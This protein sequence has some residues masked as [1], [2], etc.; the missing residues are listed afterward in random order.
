MDL[1]QRLALAVD[2]DLRRPHL[3]RG[4]DLPR[5]GGH[6]PLLGRGAA[7]RVSPHHRGGEPHR[8][9]HAARLRDHRH[10]LR[11]RVSRQG[12]GP[13][14]ARLHGAAPT[15]HVVVAGDH[16]L[17]RSAIR[18]LPAVRRARA[19]CCRRIGCR[20]ASWRLA[21]AV[22]F[23]NSALLVGL[24]RPFAGFFADTIFRPMLVIA[25]F[26][27]RDDGRH[28]RGRLHRDGLDA[29][30]RLCRASPL[31]Q[32]LFVLSAIR[33]GAGRKFPPSGARSAPLVALCAALGAD[34]AR[35]RLSSSIS[36]C[37]SLS[38][39]L[40]REEL[41]IFGVCTR[42]FSLVSFGVAAVYAVTLPDDVRE[43]GDEGPRRASTA[44]SA[45][46][47]SWLPGLRRLLFVGDGCRL[48]RSLLMLFGPSFSAGALP[49]AVSASRLSSARCS[50]RQRWCSRST[51]GPMRACPPI[52]LGLG[53]LV[54]AN[55]VLVPSL[56]ADG[57]GT[58]GADCHHALVAGAVVHR[59]EAGRGRRLDPRSP[60]E[61]RGACTSSRSRSNPASRRDRP[62]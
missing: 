16:R 46:P 59:D 51:T 17:C 18:S 43:R 25:A 45:K 62:D 10:L 39:L 35:V 61:T 58:C 23:V 47:T 60:S 19:R 29:G 12:R 44:R 31:V 56:R 50:G 36:T 37:C 15:G 4:A 3:R 8:R 30:G 28:R 27:H 57:R 2:D 26:A 5:P 38:T 21:T 52:G 20:R 7:R 6:R 9:G 53:T 14:A 34:R 33:R 32:L 49:L 13:A 41:A 24:K 22:V 40:S 55:L 54:V 1:R 48:D 11:G 42:V